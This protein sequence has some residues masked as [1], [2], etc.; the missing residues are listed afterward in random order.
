MYFKLDL[1]IPCVS[2]NEHWHPTTFQTVCSCSARRTS[3]CLAVLELWYLGLL[4]SPLL[5]R[6]GGEPVLS[7]M[8]GGS[9]SLQRLRWCSAFE[10]FR[11]NTLQTGASSLFSRN[12]SKIE[13]ICS[14]PVKLL[15]FSMFFRLDREKNRQS[16]VCFP[17]CHIWEE[18]L[19][20]YGVRT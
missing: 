11:L 5:R 8:F 1:L 10:P 17:W 3:Q 16:Y 6:A 9:G 14:F 2:L 7:N 15:S 13:P 18:Q 19:T 20:F 12:P 4:R